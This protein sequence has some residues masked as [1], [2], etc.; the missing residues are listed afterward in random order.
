MKK[1]LQKEQG[2]TLI[3][4]LASIVILTIMF[5]VLSS[6][7]VNSASYSN[8]FDKK[9]NAVQLS[10]SLLQIYQAE[11]FSEA[12]KKIGSTVNLQPSELL[13]KLDLTNEVL[14]DGDYTADVKFFKSDGVSDRLIT[15]EI[16]VASASKKVSST[17][18]GHV[19]K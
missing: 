2:F 19:R 12:E 6:F 8:S 14:S 17:I 7:F 5:S 3:E 1:A 11:G 13:E 9:L 4:V 10:K 15:I 16:T 18:K